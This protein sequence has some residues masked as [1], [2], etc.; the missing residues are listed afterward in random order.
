MPLSRRFIH[1]GPGTGKSTEIT[2]QVKE[3]IARNVRA[4]RIL[5]LTLTN[6]AANDMKRDILHNVGIPA[7]NVECSTLHSWCLGTLRRHGSFGDLAAGSQIVSEYAVHCMLWDLGNDFG[8][9]DD[10]K[11]MLHAMSSAWARQREDQPGWAVDEP[12]VRFEEAARSWLRAHGAMLLDEL[13]PR[14]LQYLRD[15]P[16]APELS[17]YDVLIVDEYQDLNSADQAIVELLAERGELLL[18]AGDDDQ[19]IYSFRYAH[20]DGIR[21]YGE[22]YHDAISSGGNVSHRCPTDVIAAARNLLRRNRPLDSHTIEPSATA[23][24]GQMRSI[25]W[26]SY[27]AEVE[28]VATLARRLVSSSVVDPG[29]VLIVTP[30]SEMGYDIADAINDDPALESPIAQTYFREDLVRNR[31]IAQRLATL[32]LVVRR[33]DASAWRV[34]LS[35]TA[36]NRRSP[37]YR[38]VLREA[39]GRGLRA[40]ELLRTL[41][42]SD[43]IPSGFSQAVGW[44]REIQAEVDSLRP[45]AGLEFLEEW[46]PEDKKTLP[47]RGYCVPYFTTGADAESVLRRLEEKIADSDPPP[48]EAGFIRIMSLHKSKGLQA[49][50]VIIAGAIA[51]LIPRRWKPEDTVLSEKAFYEEQRRLL[52]VGLTRSKDTVLVSSSRQWGGG[53]LGRAGALPGG[54]G[55]HSSIASRFLAELGPVVRSVP[56]DQISDF[57]MAEADPDRP[58]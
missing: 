1:A 27:K 50:L 34:A 5:V 52:Y 51:G 15:N 48:R 23:I 14:A 26:P 3:A 35:G 45:L 36:T 11:R 7:S 30:W 37:T 44:F 58:F 19:S 46:C 55:G 54:Y 25:Q 43:E 33:D 4:D 24:R 41:A 40:H 32:T 28:G 17:Q 49:R 57:T 29:D 47:L 12:D 21:N 42:T 53:R 16:L 13:I 6:V 22:K 39:E 31:Q 9:F 56:L 20:P 2:N 10:K 8:T 18:V 38:L